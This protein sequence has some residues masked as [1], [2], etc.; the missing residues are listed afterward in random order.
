MRP[1]LHA[2]YQNG[3]AAVS[4]DASSWFSYNR[5]VYAGC[6]R[7]AVINHAAVAE[8]WGKELSLMRGM[9]KYYLI[10]NSWGNDWGEHGYIRLLR[11]DQEN[12]HCGIDNN[13]QEGTGCEGGP[14]EVPV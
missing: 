13:P 2:L 11:H 12:E 14:T 4:V 7:N 6:D 9:F 5:G 8:G 10:R 3:P 1:L